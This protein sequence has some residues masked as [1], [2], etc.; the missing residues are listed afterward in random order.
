MHLPR[1]AAI[2]IMLERAR[3]IR[4]P[5]S[6]CQPLERRCPR[7]PHLTLISNDA[8]AIPPMDVT[9][10][11]RSNAASA[12]G[13]TPPH[14]AALRDSLPLMR[15]RIFWSFQVAFWSAIFLTAVGLSN[16]F[17]PAETTLLTSVL[18]AG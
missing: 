10:F 15:T 13:V 4:P 3:A 16:G 5:T 18:R 7:L 9:P 14:I 8:S 12:T 2:L 6:P 11:G 1:F 17:V